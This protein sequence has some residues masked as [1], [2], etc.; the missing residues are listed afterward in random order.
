MEGSGI[1][2]DPALSGYGPPTT[3]RTPEQRRGPLTCGEATGVISLTPSDAAF[4]VSVGPQRRRRSRVERLKAPITDRSTR[5][6]VG[7]KPRNAPPTKVPPTSGS[8]SM[9]ASK[10]A[11]ATSA[12]VRA[13]AAVMST[14]GPRSIRAGQVRA[15]S[16]STHRSPWPSVA[17]FAGCGRELSL[18]PPFGSA[19]SGAAS[20]K[21]VLTRSF[22][23][24]RGA[25][26]SVRCG[27]GHRARARSAPTCRCAL[28]AS[29][30]AAQRTLRG[31]GRRDL[32]GTMQPA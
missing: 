15:H 26:S 29:M 2:A 25:T 10:V 28:P 8:F 21:P 3:S 5:R 9:T 7:L 27:G 4:P 31:E 17:P 14:P 20:R 16:A 12:G 6:P 18:V 1:C 22:C 11:R 32:I 23:D 24:T 19:G 13:P 30:P